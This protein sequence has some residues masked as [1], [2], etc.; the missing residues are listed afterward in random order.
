[1]GP[2]I[3]VSRDEFAAV[4]DP[5]GGRI[6]N[7]PAYPFERLDHIFSLVIEACIDRRREGVD[8]RQNPDFPT[9]GQL[10]MNE[11]HRPDMVGMGRLRAI[12]P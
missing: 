5:N 9:R 10:V 12:G 6:T 4:V 8:N 1:M 11:V 7:P 2:K 3:E